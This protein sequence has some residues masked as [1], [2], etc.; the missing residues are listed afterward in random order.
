MNVPT[1][2]VAWNPP[3]MYHL[4][5]WKLSYFLLPVCREIY[6]HGGSSCLSI[7]QQTPFGLWTLWVP[8]LKVAVLMST[9]VFMEII[10]REIWTQ[11]S[12]HK[13]NTRTPW[14][15]Q[16]VT[17]CHLAT[18][19]DISSDLLCGKSK[20]ELRSSQVMLFTHLTCEQ[21]LGVFLGSFFKF[22]HEKNSDPFLKS[23]LLEV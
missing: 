12:R 19:M 14:M 3:L 15:E 16:Q 4:W 13:S 21:V 8:S 2:S 6:G 20:C 9:S 22:S 1:A 10:P 23:Y 17:F 11:F 18:S 7:T 5:V